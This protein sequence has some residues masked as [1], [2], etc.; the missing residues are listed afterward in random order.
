MASDL[1]IFS[2][3]AKRLILIYILNCTTAYHS[4]SRTCF[5]L[6]FANTVDNESNPADSSFVADEW[7]ELDT[8]SERELSHFIKKRVSKEYIP[9][10]KKK[11]LGCAVN[12]SSINGEGNFAKDDTHMFVPPSERQKN[13]SKKLVCIMWAVPDKIRKAPSNTHIKM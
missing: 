5:L 11:E 12:S 3:P 1:E 7:E 13:C 4:L 10:N 2:F 6:K 9:I 8:D